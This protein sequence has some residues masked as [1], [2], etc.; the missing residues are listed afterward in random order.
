MKKRDLRQLFKEIG[1]EFKNTRV[2][3]GI[4]K[5][6]VYEKIHISVETIDE[7]ENGE[8]SNIPTI[9]LRDFV[10][11]YSDFLGIRNAV[12][13]ETFLTTLDQNE[14]RI[15]KIKKNNENRKPVRII[16]I[17]MI[18]VLLLIILIQMALIQRQQSR[19]M[20]KITNKGKIEA[21]IQFEDENIP[22]KPNETLSFKVDFSGRIIN[23]EKSLIV[24][25]YYEDTWEVFFKEFEVLI[26]NGQ[27]S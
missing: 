27:D 13:V 1:E 23:T 22:L 24:V 19:E 18:P 9:Y 21:I 3:S 20:V 16:L 25:E 17:L 5:T 2:S 6:Q 8:L 4:P 14:K 15:P 7:I 10:V 26:K 12:L 11:R